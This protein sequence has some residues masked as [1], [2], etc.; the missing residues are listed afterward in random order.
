MTEVPVTC[1]IRREGSH[2]QDSRERIDGVVRN[3]LWFTHDG[4]CFTPAE[5]TGVYLRVIVPLTPE[6]ERMLNESGF[7]WSVGRKPF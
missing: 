3:G 1:E 7:L 6:I 4:R 2:N 5:M